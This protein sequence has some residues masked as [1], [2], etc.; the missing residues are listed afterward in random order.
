MGNINLKRIPIYL[1]LGEATAEE[2][3]I[4]E[5]LVMPSAEVKSLLHLKNLT[6]QTKTG[7]K[8]LQE[9]ICNI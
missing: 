7:Y 9:K 4:C 3:F 8:A 5:S 6:K 2:Y 1:T